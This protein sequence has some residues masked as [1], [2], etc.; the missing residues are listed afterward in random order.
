MS[1][2]KPFASLLAPVIVNYVAFKRGLGRQ[3]RTECRVLRLLDRFLVARNSDLTSETFTDWCI[4]L[5]HLAS[6]TRLEYLRIVRNLCCYRRRCQPTAFVPD[7]RAF[8]WPRHKFRPHL[9]TDFE[10]RRLLATA[11]A[12]PSTPESPLR[13]DTFRLAIVIL[14]TAGLRC[15]ELVRLTVGDYDSTERLLKIRDSKF[16]KSRVVPL[17]ADGAREIDRYLALRRSRRLPALPESP[18]LW[19]PYRDGLPWTGDAFGHR[20]RAL[21]QLSGVRT[22]AGK[23][24]RVHDFRHG[25]A[26]GVLLHW[27]RAGANVQAKLPLLAT[28]MGHASIISTEYYLQFIEPLAASASERF[29]RHCA[30]ILTAPP[31]VGGAP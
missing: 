16:Y 26:V 13:P 10:V 28:Y 2:L 15:G 21:F 31:I 3:Y 30:T 11:N 19:R 20:M 1:E 23:L 27:Y 7:E 29:A 12:L 6:G 14:Y 18:L 5:Q 9:F 25:F 4:N 24:P 22:L 17:S 8:R